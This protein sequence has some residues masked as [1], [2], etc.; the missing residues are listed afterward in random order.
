VAEC[1]DDEV[2]DRGAGV[3][4]VPPAGFLGA[5]AKGDVLDMMLAVLD[6]P[7]SAGVESQVAGPGEV[8]RTGR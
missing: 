7:V 2:A 5:L 3:W 8:P 6:S 4:L 1:A